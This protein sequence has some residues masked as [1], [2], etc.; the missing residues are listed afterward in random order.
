MHGYVWYL[1]LGSEK[2]GGE[3]QF[4]WLGLVRALNQL[5]T[6]VSAQ[7]KSSFAKRTAY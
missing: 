4:H 6:R 1:L 7:L 5:E 3:C 2:G